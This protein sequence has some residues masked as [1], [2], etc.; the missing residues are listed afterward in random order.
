MKKPNC[1]WRYTAAH[2]S[3]LRLCWPRGALFDRFRPAF[4]ASGPRR[5]R[6]CCVAPGRVSPEP[7]PG[8]GRSDQPLGAG[9]LSARVANPLATKSA[10]LFRDSITSP[11]AS[12]NSFSRRRCIGQQSPMT[13]N[14]PVA[15]SS[16]A[17]TRNRH[18]R[19]TG[20]YGSPDRYATL[21][22]R[23]SRSA[24]PRRTAL[25]SSCGRQ[26]GSGSHRI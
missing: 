18:G 2:R 20:H 25:G 12:G 10:S 4:R 7:R 1:R 17:G 13:A 9:D 11:I 24:R 16:G 14:T 5:H 3:G 6:P 23:V 26:N 22:Q 8:I 19:R 15:C 21:D